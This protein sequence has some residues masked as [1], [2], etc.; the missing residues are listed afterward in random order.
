MDL[1]TM[2]VQGSGM[3][4][5][6][7]SG[8]V[9]LAGKAGLHT[10]LGVESVL[11]ASPTKIHTRLTAKMS[12]GVWGTGSYYAIYEGLPAP[13]YCKVRCK[14]RK[15]W[16]GWEAAQ[17]DSAIKTSI[18]Q[19]HTRPLIS[20]LRRHVYTWMPPR[21]SLEVA[22]SVHHCFSFSYLRAI[23]CCQWVAAA[24]E[25]LM[26]PDAEVLTVNKHGEAA[27]A[28]TFSLA[29]TGPLTPFH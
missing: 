24:V 2:Q 25:N 10:D 20:C 4:T 29:R 22:V 17:A 3:S 9:V 7:D 18:F 15:L 26:S 16:C 8:L 6:Q 13:V 12:L 1:A 14:E 23:D 11:T 19:I 5:S 21:I 28:N 27:A